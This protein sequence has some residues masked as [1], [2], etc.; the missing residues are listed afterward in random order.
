MGNHNRYTNNTVFDSQLCRYLRKA[1]AQRCV[2]NYSIDIE[3]L[4]YRFFF[5]DFAL[6]VSTAGLLNTFRYFNYNY[7]TWSAVSR[8]LH[9]HVG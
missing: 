1:A 6:V 3:T 5:I 7:E 9:K 4:N 2:V 8:V